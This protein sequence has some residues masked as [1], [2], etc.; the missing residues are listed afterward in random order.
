MSLFGRDSQ[1]GFGPV[2]YESYL[3]L[4]ARRDAFELLGAAR[5]TQ[6]TVESGERSLGDVVAAVTPELAQLLHLSLDEGIAISH[7]V[8][9]SEFGAKPDV[10]RRRFASTAWTPAWPGRAGLARRSCTSAVPSTC[11]CR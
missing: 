5:E 2:S 10:R 3:S 8:W 6:A 7:R 11:G 4:E 9:Q 1:D